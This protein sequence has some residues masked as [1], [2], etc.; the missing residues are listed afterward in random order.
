MFEQGDRKPQFLGVAA[1]LNLFALNADS[2]ELEVIL[3]DAPS[4]TIVS[5]GA[6]V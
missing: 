6:R 3:L 4:L 5:T 1:S 2:V